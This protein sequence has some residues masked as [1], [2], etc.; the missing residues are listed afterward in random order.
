MVFNNITTIRILGTNINMLWRS[1]PFSRYYLIRLL[2]QNKFKKTNLIEFENFLT[3]W[4]RQI[5]SVLICDDTPCY[6]LNE[7]YEYWIEIHFN[8]D[9]EDYENWGQ[10]EECVV[11]YKITYS[12]LNW[13][14]HYYR[15]VN[16]KPEEKLL[17][18]K[19][20]GF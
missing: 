12:C 10:F 14:R 3:Y 2:Q 7:D 17:C 19:K 13:I 15:P 5:T 20:F 8:S 4:S 18:W 1:P 6:P 16:D 11:K 9:E